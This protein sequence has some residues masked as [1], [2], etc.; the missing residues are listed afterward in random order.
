MN[1]SP[2]KIL[3]YMLVGFI[4]IAI[5]AVIVSKSSTTPTA[6]QSLGVA[7]TNIFAAIV[8]P[9][10]SGTAQASAAAST[11]A[12]GPVANNGIGTANAGGVT[13]PTA[14]DSGAAASADTGTTAVNH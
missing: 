1:S 14:T 11:A 9:I 4:G 6:L 13:A 2:G 3:E 10:S 12:T 8:A 7:L 5:V